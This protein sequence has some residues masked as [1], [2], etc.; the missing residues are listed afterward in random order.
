[1]QNIPATHIWVWQNLLS[2]SRHIWSWSQNLIKGSL[3]CSTFYFP[4][5]HRHMQSQGA[6]CW[7][8]HVFVKSLRKVVLT[9]ENYQK[10]PLRREQ[11]NGSLIG[12][13][14]PMH[15]VG[16]VMCIVWDIFHEENACTMSTSDNEHA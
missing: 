14:H 11:V 3:G 8:Q 6:R 12:W 2:N 15:G 7:R 9:K 4:K 13:T 5:T 1:V 16:A 10:T